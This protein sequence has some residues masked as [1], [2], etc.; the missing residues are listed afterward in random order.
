MWYEVISLTMSYGISMYVVSIIYHIGNI[1]YSVS[2]L[3]P[4]YNVVYRWAITIVLTMPY[5]SILIQ[6]PDRGW[7]MSIDT[8]WVEIWHYR[9]KGYHL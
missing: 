7:W 2:L 6:V 8:S 9:N 3:K 5:P 1:L 4:L